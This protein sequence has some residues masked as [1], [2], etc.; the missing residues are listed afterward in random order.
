MCP[1]P[2]PFDFVPFADVS[3]V[4]KSIEEWLGSGP[5]C[6]G[7]LTVKLEALTPLHIVGEQVGN[8]NQIQQSLFYQRSGKPYIPG[9]SIRGVLRSFIEA[10]CNCCASQMTPFYPKTPKQHAIGFSVLKHSEL[11]ENEKEKVDKN[12]QALDTKFLVSASS[13]KG[14][15]LA[16]FLFGYVHENS[17][18]Q[19]EKQIINSA[20]KGKIIIEDAP[21]AEKYLSLK[22]DNNPYEIPDLRDSDA[23]MGG[24]HPSASSW[25]YQYPYKIIKDR[26]NNFN[27]IK[28]I[29]SGYR[30]RKFYFH[31]DSFNCTQLYLNSKEWNPDG[32]NLY[33]INIQCLKK[34]AITESFPIFFNDIPKAFLKLLIFALEPGNHI[35]HKLGYGKAYGYGSVN[36]SVADGFYHGTGFDDPIPIPVDVLRRE[37][38]EEL[39][40]PAE[41]NENGFN[42][43]LHFPTLDTLAKILW[44]D[45]PLTYVFMYPYFGKGGFLQSKDVGS[46]LDALLNPSEK[47]FLDT[48]W[49]FVNKEQKGDKI[50]ERL[51]G[52]KPALHFGVYQKNSFRYTEL[53]LKRSFRKSLNV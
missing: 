14:V 53:Y 45:D 17:D 12:I 41:I 6:S 43:F 32:T 20:W 44:Y 21:V 42:Q 30:G 11:S 29:G 49:L 13:E 51:Y 16:S 1:Y 3:P 4:K 8:E 39:K 24:P 40:N 48:K 37:A 47:T 9:T 27:N 46:E 19:S 23:F 52:I 25:W 26:S 31:Q 7:Y 5:L 10:A 35:R 38:L 15:D 36:F 33:P 22:E 2:N 50:A 18:M 34:G 28:F